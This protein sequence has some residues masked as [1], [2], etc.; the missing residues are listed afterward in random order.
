MTINDFQI[1]LINL[2]KGLVN[3]ANRLT[4]NKEDAKDLV[5]DT[6]LK[7][8]KCYDKFVHESNLRAWIY[9][10]MK[11][12]FINNYRR[13]KD[14]NTYYIQTYEV[15]Y[16]SFL[17]CSGTNNPESEYT[18]K[19]IKIRIEAL[20]DNFKLPLIMHHEGYKYKEIAETLDMNIG[21][22]KS[23]IFFARK[24]MKKQLAGYY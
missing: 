9:T 20:D 1:N 21:T 13:I 16:Q 10:V 5:Q 19:D 12:T 24:K 11:N 15:F 18:A 8:L 22:V 23:R 17:Y 14:H 4:S 3:F 2:Q 6:Y 7:A